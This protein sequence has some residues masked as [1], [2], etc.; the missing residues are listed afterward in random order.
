MRMFLRLIGL[1]VLLVA[2]LVG[3]AFALPDRAHVERSITI[4]RPQAQVWLLL[5]NLRRF[6]E[7]SPWYA[8]DPAARYTY[9]GPEAAV[10]SRLAWASE[11]RDVGSG[12]QTIVA[13]K[14]FESVAL[15]LDFGDLGKSQARYELRTESNETRVTWRLDSELPLHLD[16]RFGWNVLGRYMGLFMDRLTGPDF[17]QG[18]LNLRALADTFPNIDIA[19]I[20]PQLVQVPVR[21]LIYVEVDS[22]TDDAALKRAWEAGLLQLHRFIVQH[23]LKAGSAPLALTRRRDAGN[24]SFEL[25]LPAEYDLM[26]GDT[27]VRGRVLPAGSAVQLTHSGSL[28]ARQRETEK[29]QAWMTVKGLP[30]GAPL[31]EEYAENAD[32]LQGQVRILLPLQVSAQN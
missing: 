24:W 11:R 26:P 20:T 7:W 14:P 19:D 21:K 10:G 5:S 32:V 9:S 30:A 8:R 18:L 6:N 3:L 29:L 25:A 23:G 28:Q 12:S 27:A 15:E 4:A 17:E 22:A 2:L 13:L 16:Q 1:F 31:V